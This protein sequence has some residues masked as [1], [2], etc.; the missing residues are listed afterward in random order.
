MVNDDSAAKFQTA[1]QL[2]CRVDL[3]LKYACV[4]IIIGEQGTVFHKALAVGRLFLI[5][6]KS[7]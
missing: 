2:V 6:V 3:I 5:R 1:S 4:C 7:P